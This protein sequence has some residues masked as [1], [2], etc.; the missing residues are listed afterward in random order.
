MSI[1]VSIVEDDAGIR[2]G[3]IRI[4]GRSRDFRCLG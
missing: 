2:D 1:T 4:L 3:L